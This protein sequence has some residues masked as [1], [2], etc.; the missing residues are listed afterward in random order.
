MEYLNYASYALSII[1]LIFCVQA[2]IK[3]YRYR[4]AMKPHKDY[5]KQREKLKALGLK[6]FKFNNGET[7]IWAD[8][9]KRA[10]R[11]YFKN[12]SRNHQSKSSKPKS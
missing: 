7:E 8:N 5:E 6:P 10:Q 4:K 2:V 9:F 1:F 3:E 12:T 11:E